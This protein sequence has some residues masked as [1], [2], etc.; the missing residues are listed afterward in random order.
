MKTRTKLLTAVL[1]T[2]TALSCALTAAAAP[3]ITLQGNEAKPAAAEDGSVT[4]TLSA[5]DFKSVAGADLEITLNDGITLTGITVTKAGGT[6]WTPALNENYAVK[7]NKLKI[8][9]IFNMGT[10][11]NPSLDLSVEFKF[12]DANIGSYGFANNIRLVDENEQDITHSVTLGKLVIGKK[13]EEVV[14][15]GSAQLFDDKNSFVP[16]GILKDDKG[17]YIQKD[18][19]GA[20]TFTDKKSITRFKLPVGNAVTTFGASYDDDFEGSN[21]VQFGS[22][23]HSIAAEANSFGTVLIY[24][25]DLTGAGV[26]DYK[27]GSYEGAVEYFGSADELFKDIIT[28]FGTKNKI[29]GKF[30]P[31]AYGGNGNTNDSVIY[32]CVVK[33]NN[34]MWKHYKEDKTL[35]RLQYAVRCKTSTPDRDFTAVGYIKNKDET[36][37]FSTEIKTESYN[38]LSKDQLSKDQ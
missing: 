10:D 7:N 36:Y 5:T 1:S 12:D 15:N 13:A 31:Y 20:F 8:V 18:E 24:S 37:S 22:Y 11:S 27:K 28:K 23:I 25:K 38:S 17:V 21:T 30:H 6:A 14:G 16:Y 26:K 29:D 35:D 19:S 4:L 3:A 32:A 2:V 34:Y 33:Q 9:D